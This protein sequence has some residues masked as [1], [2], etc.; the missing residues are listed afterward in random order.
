MLRRYMTML[1][2]T[3]LG[4][5]LALTTTATA[6]A[7]ADLPRFEPGPCPI[8][9]PE[10]AIVECG[11]L[12]APE[13]YEN[14]AGRTVRLPV[15]IIRSPNPNA[16]PDP[17][18]F[19]QGGPGH[20]SV[21][22]V[23][24]F[25]RS[26][27]VQDR[28]VVILEQR[29]N[30][31]AQPSLDCDVDVWLVEGEGHTPCL[32]SLRARS[33]DPLHYTAATIA[34]DVGSL[35]DV[36]DYE[37]WN[38]YGSSFST[39][40][41]ILAMRDHPDRIRS[42]ILQSVN[43]PTDTRYAH[44]PE[45]AVRPL[46]LL[47]ADCAGDPACAAAYP[48]L[49]DQFY[50][51][52]SRLN[53]EPLRLE[54]SDTG[55]NDVVTF[56]VD[57][58]ALLGWMVG[59]AFYGPTRG[60]HRTAFLPYLI[61]AVE[62]GNT[63]LLYPWAREEWN[64]QNTWPF[65]WGLFFAVNCQDDTRGYTAASLAAQSAA[66]P[67]LEGYARQERELEICNAWGLP[68][69]PPLLERPLESDIPTLV[70]AGSYDP[71]TPPAWSRE[72]ARYLENATYV[73]FPAEGHDVLT[74]NPC[75]LGIMSD[76]L[77]DPSHQPEVSCAAAAPQFVLPDDVLLVPNFFEYYVGYIGRNKLEHDAYLALENALPLAIVLVLAV[78]VVWLLLWRRRKV[79]F[80][81]VVFGGLLLAVLVSFLWYAVSMQMRAL[82][83]RVAGSALL[84]FG[85]PA[86][87]DTTAWFVAVLVVAALTA[88]LVALVIYAW[89][90]GR[91]PLLARVALAVVMLP[92]VG[93]TVLLGAW[94]WLGVLL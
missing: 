65:A 17:L 46:E 59:D 2:L 31:Y 18:L 41:M 20:T 55:T 42:V 8:E 43:A 21:N 23:Q 49:E 34:A 63:G 88:G 29:G 75:S 67:K 48:N 78:V 38:L 92:A 26:S 74:D 10:E 93:F 30:L 14:P 70:L 5:C 24:D 53:A 45:H 94:G 6:N 50:T 37:Q 3:I 79:R 11:T 87:A 84:R 90:R 4:I 73:E 81:R 72:T 76:F 66:Y 89:V 19:T 91:V 25:S 61:D 51:L 86:A 54:M 32:D 40:L 33:I 77:R 44:D 12:V 15:F 69:A 35:L 62:T 83:H 36:L 82:S 9:V 85:V 28:D 47:F 52:F 7:A 71:I 27:F 1:I 64:K 22:S 68:P 13:D 60:Y 16:A 58:Y 80:D 56:T 39:R 57:G